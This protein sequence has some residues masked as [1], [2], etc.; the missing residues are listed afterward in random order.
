MSV[1][2]LQGLFPHDKSK[3]LFTCYILITC[4]SN[5]DLS[6]KKVKEKEKTITSPA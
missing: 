6:E 3:T 4:Q 1:K 2:D 5:L